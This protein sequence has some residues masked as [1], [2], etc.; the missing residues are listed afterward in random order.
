MNL[1][2]IS[3]LPKLT[4]VL[5]GQDDSIYKPMWD[6]AFQLILYSP[7]QFSNFLRQEE[8]NESKGSFI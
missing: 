1:V 3:Q 5:K 7:V 6:Y 8:A 2:I 4:A